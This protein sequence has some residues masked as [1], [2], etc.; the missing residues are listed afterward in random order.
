MVLWEKVC[1]ILILGQ[2]QLA[3]FLWEAVWHSCFKEWVDHDMAQF[4]KLGVGQEMYSRARIAWLMG[5]SPKTSFQYEQIWALINSLLK[6]FL[7]F[8][9]V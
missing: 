8:D 1:R 6:R 4:H 2:S 3:T 9:V 5:E 7:S